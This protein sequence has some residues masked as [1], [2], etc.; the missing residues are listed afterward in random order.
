MLGDEVPSAR[1]AEGTAHLRLVGAQRAWEAGQKAIMGVLPWQA[2]TYKT[3]THTLSGDVE[4][5]PKLWV[6]SDHSL[7]FKTSE[8]DGGS[9]GGG[10]LLG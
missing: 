1:K 10:V 2:L 9:R 7:Q 6:D 4:Q 3:H 8:G 5:R